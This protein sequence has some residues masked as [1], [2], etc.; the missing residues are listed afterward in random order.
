MYFYYY[1]CFTKK[2]IQWIDKEKQHTQ[3]RKRR[4]RLRKK[5][6]KEMKEKERGITQKFPTICESCQRMEEIAQFWDAHI[7]L[8]IVMQKLRTKYY[9]F[10]SLRWRLLKG[11]YPNTIQIPFIYLYRIARV[12]LKNSRALGLSN[13][14][15]SSVLRTI[16]RI[17]CNNVIS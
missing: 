10:N 15:N 6:L 13:W 14:N 3:Y 7:E 5:L 16:F 2:G 4:K 8:D 1:V 9:I 11:L 12:R 17:T